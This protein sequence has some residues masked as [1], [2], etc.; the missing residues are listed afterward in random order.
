MA[1]I[2]TTAFFNGDG[3]L[4]TN[5]LPGIKNRK[6]KLVIAFE[7]DAVNLEDEMSILIKSYVADE[8]DYAGNTVNEPKV[9]YDTINEGDIALV[10]LPQSV[11]AIKL[12]PALVL[13]RLPTYRDFL[14]C[15]ISTQQHHYI[16]NFDEMIDENSP[17]FPFTG[18][19]KTSVVRLSSLAV[20]S[21]DKIL[22][23]IG[24]IPPPLH[25]NLLKRLADFILG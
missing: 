19:H 22:N 14:V 11:G 16:N 1:T 2:E 20:F 10:E 15:G 25:E 9:E 13:K 12:R 24:K 5:K 17:L 23:S 21:M 8:P 18:L 4:V 3:E 6:V 7:D